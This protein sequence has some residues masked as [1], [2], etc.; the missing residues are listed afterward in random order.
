MPNLNPHR[1]KQWQQE[2]DLYA[3]KVSATV[4]ISWFIKGQQAIWS[5]P[6]IPKGFKVGGTRHYE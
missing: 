2:Q 3:K 6:P 5:K 1:E 4:A